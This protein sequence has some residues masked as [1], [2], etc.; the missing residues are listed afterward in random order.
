MG[1]I[2]TL[3]VLKKAISLLKIEQALK[4][5]AL[6]EQFQQT[7]ES[8]KPVSILKSLARDTIASPNLIVTILTTSIGLATGFYAKKII[9]GASAGI[10]RKLMGSAVSSGVTSIIARNPEVLNSAGKFISRFVSAHKKPK[11]MVKQM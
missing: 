2:T 8:L 6:K 10:I 3:P 1:T 4:G 9:V 7:Y 5:N 11:R